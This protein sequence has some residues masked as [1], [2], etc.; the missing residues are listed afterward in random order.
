M[1]KE[2]LPILASVATLL[3]LDVM[4]ITG[5]MQKPYST[6]ISKIQGSDISM[7]KLFAVM[8]YVLMV[9][10]LIMFVIPR[11]Q[12]EFSWKKTAMIGALFGIIVYGVYDFTAAAVLKD[13][14]IPL[15][16]LDITWGGTVYAI[17]SLVYLYFIQE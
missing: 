7:N 4:W 5:V 3:L 1:N 16:L 12:K 14:N 9:V 10:G 11:I 13:W 6:M 15:A 8:A 17:A 2:F